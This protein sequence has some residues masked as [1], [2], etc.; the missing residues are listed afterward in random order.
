MSLR[1]AAAH[2]PHP[3]HH[4]G[5]RRPRAAEGAWYYE[6]R[7]LGFNYRITDFQCALGLSQLARL[8]GW[9]DHAQ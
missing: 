4:E 5:G 9:I 2:V 8:D 7:A 6:M 3:R 1:T